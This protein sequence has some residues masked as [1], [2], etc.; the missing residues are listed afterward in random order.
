[1]LEREIFLLKE[2]DLTPLKGDHCLFKKKNSDLML[3]IYVDDGLLV[4]SDE[5]EIVTLL[6]ELENR[7]EMTINRNPQTFLGMELHQTEDG[8]RLTQSC[9]TAKVLNRYGKENCKPMS[10]PINK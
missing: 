2:K 6:K 3:A 8:T 7:F 9:Y 5:S 4:S 1:M 10:T